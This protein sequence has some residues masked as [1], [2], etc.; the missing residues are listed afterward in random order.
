MVI[1]A[2]LH[3]NKTQIHNQ[4]AQQLMPVSYTHLGEEIKKNNM[5]VDFHPSEYCVLNST[6]KEVV[7][8]SLDILQYHYNLLMFLDIKEPLSVLHIVSKESGKEKAITRLLITLKNYPSL[9]KILLL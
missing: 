8:Q 3:H 6:K 4:T 7:N 5:R 9:Y 2:K 1:K